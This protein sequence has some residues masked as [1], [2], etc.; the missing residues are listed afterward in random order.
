MKFTIPIYVCRHPAQK[1]SAAYYQ[2]QPLFTH[3][4]QEHN[5]LL[6]RALTRLAQKLRRA[7]Q[8]TDRVNEAAVLSWWSFC[9]EL[10]ERRSDVP[11]RLRR[12][13]ASCRYLLVSW[14]ALG[15]TI[16]FTPS[17]PKVWFELHEG[18]SVAERASEVLSHYFKRVEETMEE[19]RPE[20]L[21]I[22][23]EAF[24]TT[25]T[26]EIFLPVK[27]H[28]NKMSASPHAFLLAEEKVSGEAE[29]E[30][31]GE[32]WD[33]LYPDDL[34]RAL[35]RDQEVG[36][37]TSLLQ[38]PD[39]RP[40]LLLGPRQS[41]KTA[42]IHECLYR[43]LDRRR[44]PFRSRG[45]L[46]HLSPQRLISGMSRV[47]EW[48]NRILAILREASRRDYILYFDDLLGLYLAGISLDSS[49]NMAQVIKPYI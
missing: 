37:L 18:E 2:V 42:I 8:G 27:E 25:L 31:T 26:I 20:E 22:K 1:D 48:E 11:I 30:K 45:K 17:V 21:S 43:L 33:L 13:V 10:K 49:L 35:L 32:C 12:R 15:R 28:E 36:E 40:V 46:W 9:P 38:A 41:G 34:D 7:I 23:S 44:N 14:Q 6:N 19:L 24:I 29:L 47:G 4:Y 5:E 16:A 39:K 3:D